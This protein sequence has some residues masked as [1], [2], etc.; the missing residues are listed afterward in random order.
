[1]K[2][3]IDNKGTEIITKNEEINIEKRSEI[4]LLKKQ[5]ENLINQKR[6]T[7]QMLNVL[8]KYMQLKENFL[9][10]K[11]KYKTVGMPYSHN[12][13]FCDKAKKKFPQ[14]IIEDHII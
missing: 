6:K 9:K 7:E 5:K 12:K 10:N 13:L 11:Q 3:N 8:K 14:H 2:E 4:I 1:M